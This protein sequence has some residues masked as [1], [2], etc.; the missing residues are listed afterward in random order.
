[1]AKYLTEE[2]FLNAN[3]Y[4][5]VA[6]KAMEARE[7]AKRCIVEIQITSQNG[8]EKADVLPPMY[9][10]SPFL[11]SLY[12]MTFLLYHYF[13]KLIPNENGEL[14]LN[15]KEYDEWGEGSL[16]NTIERFKMSKNIDV[17]NKAF[18]I[19]AD[20]REFYRMLGTEIAS[21]LTAKNDLLTRFMDFF[22]SSI[23]PDTFEGLLKQLKDVQTEIDEYQ[24]QPKEW[25]KPTLEEVK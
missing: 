14:S 3:S 22:K 6:E 20:Y 19:A 12:G 17:R 9:Q 24:A 25:K 8:S 21:I 1:M 10:E 13:D 16:L 2:D 18:D 5:P 15:A 4:V 11:K 23:T 7:Y